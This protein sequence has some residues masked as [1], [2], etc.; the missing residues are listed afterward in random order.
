MITR[1]ELIKNCPAVLGTKS[2][3]R[4]ERYLHVNTMD[5]IDQVLATGDWK[6]TKALNVG[7]NAQGKHQITFEVDGW[8]QNTDDLGKI[9]PRFILT[10]SH[11]G[12]THLTFNTGLFRKVCANGLV[13]PL[14]NSNHSA[15]IKHIAINGDLIKNSLFTTLTDGKNILGKITKMRNTDMFEDAKIDMVRE[16]LLIKNRITTNDAER[17]ISEIPQ[18]VIADVLRPNRT[19]DSGNSV[20]NVFNTVQENT[21]RGNYTSTRKQRELTDFRLTDK[22]NQR[23]FEKALALV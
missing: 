18:E 13:L 6:I 21:I 22:L 8:Y 19:E 11:D 20:W 14:A 17:F 10:N 7:G 5:I 15:K 9:K 12:T 2:P 16:A 4:S 23:L 3:E 1:E